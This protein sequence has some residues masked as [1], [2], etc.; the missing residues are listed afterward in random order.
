MLLSLATPAAA[1]VADQLPKELSGVSVQQKLGNHVNLALPFTTHTGEAITLRKFF[2]DGK[3]VILTL[4]Y[5]RCRTLCSLE[6]NALV[7]GLKELSFKAGTEF[8]VITASID[9]RETPKLAFGKRKRYLESLGQGENVDWTFLTGSEASVRALAAQVGFT[10]RYIKEQDEFAHP[11]V[12]FVLSPE[13]K[14]VRYLEGLGE[15]GKDGQGLNI[16]ARDLKFAIMDASEG[17]VGSL[18]DKFIQSCF[19]YDPSLGRYGAFAMGIMRIGGILTVV[20]LAIVLGAFWRRERR[21]RRM[22][23]AT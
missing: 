15:P 1:Q 21:I 13:G 7:N 12:I 6:L 20:I 23:E 3:P 5:Y 10:F 14:I 17:K 19:H 16:P 11:A 9:H 2:G 22:A 18:L 4:N 8:R